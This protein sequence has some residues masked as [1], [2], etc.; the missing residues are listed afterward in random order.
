[1][2]TVNIDAIVFGV[3][4]AAVAAVGVLA[5]RKEKESDDYFLASRSL[6][7]WTLLSSVIC[8]KRKGS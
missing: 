7:W 2:G 5:S 8:S 1:M 6:T 4:L 3:Y